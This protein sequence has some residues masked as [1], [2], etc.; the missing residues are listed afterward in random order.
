MITTFIVQMLGG[1]VSG[2]F[3]LLPSWN[4]GNDVLEPVKSMSVSAA[5]LDGWL[6]QNFIFGCL[7]MMIAVRLW[8]LVIDGIQWVYH[9][10]PFN[11]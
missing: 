1:I 9:L 8:F 4:V 5:S 7:L 2:I 3:S 6:P 11:H 10:I